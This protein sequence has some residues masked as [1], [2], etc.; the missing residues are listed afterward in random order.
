MRVAVFDLVL[1]VFVFVVALVFLVLVADLDVLAAFFFGVF[2]AV[3]FVALGWPL[4]QPGFGVR[5][6]FQQDLMRSRG[7]RI[8]NELRGK[9]MQQRTVVSALAL[10]YCAFQPRHAMLFWL[11]SL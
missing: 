8:G 10:W 1:V 4:R 5:V 7:I 3:F 11:L 9:L 6:D 2:F